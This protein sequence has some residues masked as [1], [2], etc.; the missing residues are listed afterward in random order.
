MLKDITYNSDFLNSLFAEKDFSFINGTDKESEDLQ[1]KIKQQESER[2][3]IIYF[4]NS[5]N[6]I[7]SLPENK[8]SELFSKSLNSANKIFEDINENIKSLHTLDSILE[9]IKQ[10]IVNLLI[11]IESSASDESLYTDRAFTIKS[12]I[13]NYSTTLNNIKNKILLNDIKIDN[14]FHNTSIENFS[15]N[16]DALFPQNNEVT[17]KDEL[18]NNKIDINFTPNDIINENT[19][20]I[21]N[22][23]TLTISEKSGKIFL[24]YKESEINAYLEQYPEQYRS[25]E[26]VVNKEFILP[27]ENYIKHSVVS[28]FRETYYLIRDREAKSVIEALKYGIDLMFK[29]ELA[30][31]IVAACKTQS[32]LENYLDCLEHNQLENFKDFKIVFE[33]NPL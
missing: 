11:L 7:I 23:D 8:N 18:V 17:T 22:N 21:K 20:I 2:E 32:Q 30:P 13:N 3:H 33:I 6:N 1:L 10:D 12:S 15:F 29:S 28:R 27:I 19:N 4:I 5:L 24:P 31:A 9:K 26:D 16:F 14:L 25:F